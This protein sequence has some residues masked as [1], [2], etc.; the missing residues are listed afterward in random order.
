MRACSRSLA[1]CRASRRFLGAP[2]A[3]QRHSSTVRGTRSDGP[4]SAVETATHETTAC[5]D[6]RDA[7]A[8]RA[9]GTFQSHRES[10]RVKL[11]LRGRIWQL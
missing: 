10:A 11:T 3:P 5:F 6:H 1:V 2:L 4:L 9:R 8:A 7:S